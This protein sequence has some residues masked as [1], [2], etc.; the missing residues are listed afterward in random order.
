MTDPILSPFRVLTSRMNSSRLPFDFAPMLA[1]IGI[2]LLISLLN[3][4]S[5]YL[6]RIIYLSQASGFPLA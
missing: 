6:Y 2:W 1:L 5:F 4:L 3:R